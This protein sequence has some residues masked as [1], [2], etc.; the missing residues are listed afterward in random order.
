M[1]IEK[2]VHDKLQSIEATLAGVSDILPMLQ[3]PDSGPMSPLP[4]SKSILS[5]YESLGSVVDPAG[6]GQEQQQGGTHTALG[7][8]TSIRD[9]SQVISHLVNGHNVHHIV[10]PVVLSVLSTILYYVFIVIQVDEEVV[11]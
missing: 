4:S 11:V 8:D 5:P 10:W 9:A 7:H 1:L 2:H 6:T 3:M